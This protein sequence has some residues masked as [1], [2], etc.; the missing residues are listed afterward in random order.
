MLNFAFDIIPNLG[1]L[2]CFCCCPSPHLICQ[3]ASLF[4]L[5]D[6]SCWWFWPGPNFNRRLSLRILLCT[7]HHWIDTLWLEF[8]VYLFLLLSSFCNPD[9]DFCHSDWDWFWCVCVI[10]ICVQNYVWNLLDQHLLCTVNFFFFWTPTNLK[11]PFLFDAF[12][13]SFKKKKIAVYLLLLLCLFIFTTCA[14]HFMR[15]L[16]WIPLW[17]ADDAWPACLMPS[18]TCLH[19]AMSVASSYPCPLSPAYPLSAQ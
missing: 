13:S 2:F 15:S 4:R 18:W 17:M 1:F 6:P 10:V 14:R 19:T 3:P 11:M 5:T 12:V 9:F 8:C 16:A 7:L